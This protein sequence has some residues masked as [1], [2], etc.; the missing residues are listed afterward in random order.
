MRERGP[1]AAYLPVRGTDFPDAAFTGQ[2]GQPLRAQAL[3]LPNISGEVWVDSP[4]SSGRKISIPSG[5]YRYST[6]WTILK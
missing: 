2:S 1:Y 6:S 4:D 3:E 5:D